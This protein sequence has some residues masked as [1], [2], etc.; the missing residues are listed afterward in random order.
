MR[1]SMVIMGGFVLLSFVS[2]QVCFAQLINH[3]RRYRNTAPAN[4]N[5]QATPQ[6]T[7]N[8]PA[9]IAPATPAVP[10]IP[11]APV[12]PVVTPVAAQNEAYGM[13]ENKMAHQP[14][15]ETN[16]FLKEV[17]ATVNKN[18][19]Y[20]VNSDLLKKYDKNKDGMISR[21]EAKMIESTLR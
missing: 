19:F 17:V 6:N 15:M 20:K 1:K 9:P 12:A 2:S 3:N 7:Y 14:M 4:T 13:N 21:A 10:A 8:R 16:A 11:A 5:T 18:G